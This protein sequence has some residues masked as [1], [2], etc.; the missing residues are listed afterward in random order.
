[1]GASYE[2]G[3]KSSKLYEEGCKAGARY[4]NADPEEIGKIYLFRQR[5]CNAE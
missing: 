1:M 3:Q 5:A 2:V 4:I